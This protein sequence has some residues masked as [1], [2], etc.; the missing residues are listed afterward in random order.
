MRTNSLAARTAARKAKR[1]RIFGP[2][3]VCMFCKFDNPVALIAV[4][5]TLL[6]EHHV[7]GAAHED[8]TRIPV[9]RNCH[10][11][12]TEGLLENGTS[13]KSK[14]SLLERIVEMCRALEVFH[15][16]AAV[17]NTDLAAELDDYIADQTNIRMG[18]DEPDYGHRGTD[19]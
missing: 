5:R 15:R 11:L 10:A 16:A 6:E 13:M 8:G 3:A 17:A 7:H 12:L 2:N 14:R 19:Q 1:S 9:C 4:N 18:L